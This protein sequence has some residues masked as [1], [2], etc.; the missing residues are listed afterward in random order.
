MLEY[1]LSFL[2]GLFTIEERAMTARQIQKVKLPTTVGCGALAMWSVYALVVSEL[3]GR[4]PLFQTLFMM[5]SF[6]FVIM[7]LRLT[8]SGGWRLPKQPW[9]IW[10][11]AGYWLDKNDYYDTIRYIALLSGMTGV[12]V[13]I[14]FRWYKDRSL[15]MKTTVQ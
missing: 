5:F 6:S 7:A 4:L 14:L 1:H 10:L 15:E 9:F 11:I 3:V 2:G 8:A 13:V 12:F